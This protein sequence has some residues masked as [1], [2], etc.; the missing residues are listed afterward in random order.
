MSITAFTHADDPVQLAVQLLHDNGLDV[1]I[2]RW[3]PPAG[4]CLGILARDG[5]QLVAVQVVIVRPG[6]SEG[7]LS[8]LVEEHAEATRAAAED[9][10]REHKLRFAS[11]RVDA[12]FLAWQWA[13]LW[14]GLQVEA[15][16]PAV[17]VPDEAPLG[18]SRDS[19]QS[20]PADP[21]PAAGAAQSREP[22]STDPGPRLSSEEETVFGT[23]P[24][25]LGWDDSA[26]IA[27]DAGLPA[28]TVRQCLSNLEEYGL[29]QRWPYQDRWH[30]AGRAEEQ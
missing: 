20:A 10:I 15:V 5:D 30:K 3:S 11:L 19:G 13:N 14:T 23:L 2:P 28:E 6:E 4:P 8:W 22:D 9:W 16:L 18:D 24:G 29:A 17:L 21:P 25:G 27:A 26:T 12:F 7:Q 1:I